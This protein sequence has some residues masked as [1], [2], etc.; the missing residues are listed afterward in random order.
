MIQANDR[1]FMIRRPYWWAFIVFCITVPGSLADTAGKEAAISRRN[2]LYGD[3]LPAGA[4]ARLGSV[5]LRH[6]ALSDLVFLPDYKSIVSAGGDRVLR[7]WDIATGKPVRTVRLQGT[8]SPGYAVPLS[9]DGRT[10]VSFDQGNLVSW[11]VDTGK[12]LKRQP[13]GQGAGKRPS[14]QT[15]HQYGS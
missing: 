12:E 10:L 6:A 9:P 8:A 13:N 11:D 14:W 2:D 7:F 4:V 5:R 1:I 3:P 15:T